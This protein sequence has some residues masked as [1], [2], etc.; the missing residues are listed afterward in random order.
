MLAWMLNIRAQVLRE[1]KE[2]IMGE[3]QSR[4]EQEAKDLSDFV[5]CED[6]TDAEQVCEL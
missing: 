4:S 6:Y 5:E 3:P 1:C 2:E